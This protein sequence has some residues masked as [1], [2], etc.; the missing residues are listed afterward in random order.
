MWIYEV[1]SLSGTD[2][3]MK[4]VLD[5]KGRDGWELVSV[6]KGISQL[7]VTRQAMTEEADRLQAFLKRL[8]NTG[9]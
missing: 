2:A 7:S 6:V 8:S 5:K 4:A 3:D 9:E 1:V